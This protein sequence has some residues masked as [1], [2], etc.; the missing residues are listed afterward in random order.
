MKVIYYM[1]YLQNYINI[2]TDLHGTVTKLTNLIKNVSCDIYK[3]LL[4]LT[5]TVV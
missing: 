1:Q 5:V 4:N 2:L 3:H